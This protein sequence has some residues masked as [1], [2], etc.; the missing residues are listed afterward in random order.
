[1]AGTHAAR[2][3]G[4]AAALVLLVCA[5]APACGLFERSRPG[6]STGNTTDPRWVHRNVPRADVAVVFVHGIFGDT[7]GTWTHDS[8]T[9]VF[10]LLE[11][12]PDIGPRVDLFAF[13]YT[14]NMFRSGSLSIQ[15]AANSLHQRLMLEQVLDYPA[16]VFVAHSMGGLVV[17][18]ELLTHREDLLPRVRGLV[19]Y[20]TPQEGSQITRIAQYA[21]ENQAIGEML[22]G[23]QNLSLQQLDSEWRALRSRPQIHC[24]YEK[25]PTHGVAIVGMMSATRFCDIAPV[26]IDADHIDIVKPD[27]ASHDTMMVLVNALNAFALGRAVRGVLETPDFVREQDHFVFTM[28][29]PFGRSVA[30][31]S[32]SGGSPLRYTFGPAAPPQ[33]YVWP[34]DTPK[35]LA[36]GGDERVRFALA[37][38]ATAAEYRVTLTSDVSEPAS[39][40]VRVPD[41]AALVTQQ[42]RLAED[43]ARDVNALLGDPT[44]SAVFA[45][46][47]A[48]DPEVP[49]AVT[50]AVRDAVARRSADLPESAT[51]V[52]AADLMDA[53]NWHGLAIRALRH[54]EEASPATARAPAV[55][56]LAGMVAARAGQPS[57]F[58]SAP[59]V[60]MTGPVPERPQPFVDASAAATSTELARLM[61]RVPALETQGLSLQGDLER[62]RGDVAGAQRTFTAAAAIRPSPSL[63]SRL[64]SV[65]ASAVPKKK[66]PLKRP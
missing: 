51:W 2:S 53:G 61:Q 50:R 44:K 4:V 23:D 6:P 42:V 29:D 17:L 24:A 5:G 56:H 19:F 15:E 35:T 26:A 14:S 10:S 18:R 49:E 13:G 20:A 9:S 39:I 21:A 16:V 30:R 38:G 60:P 57:V 28:T 31:L 41:M 34:D 58:A 54:A 48:S 52:V 55:Q 22:P 27:R 40:A 33:L 25:R 47:A 65:A 36:A 59:T 62:A 46:A 8:G 63:S 32:N 45:A 7:V 37:F 66:Q 11:D 1:M 12:N 64:A 3:R 43:V